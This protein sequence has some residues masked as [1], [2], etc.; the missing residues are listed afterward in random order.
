M[1]RLQAVL[2]EH[3]VEFS[4]VSGITDAEI[5]DE[6]RR[7]DMVLFASMFEGFGLPILEAQA[8]GRPVVTSRAWSMPEVAG[9][10]AC[11]VDPFDV[12][13]I[14]DGV[15][16]VITDVEYRNG[17]VRAGLENVGRFRPARIAE[18]YAEIYREL[19]GQ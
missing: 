12:Q 5:V 8:T 13:S 15:K 11:L 18:Q 16:R 6:Y 1:P 2:R 14:H 19:A 10:A 9:K 17:L 4:C 3:G 7:C